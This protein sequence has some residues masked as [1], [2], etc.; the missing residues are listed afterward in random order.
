MWAQPRPALRGQPARHSPSQAGA[1][2]PLLC[3]SSLPAHPRTPGRAPSARCLFCSLRVSVGW[4]VG[5]CCISPADGRQPG[6]SSMAPPQGLWKADTEGQNK[7]LAGEQPRLPVSFIQPKL[8]KIPLQNVFQLPHHLPGTHP[9][10]APCTLHPHKNSRSSDGTR[11]TQC[12][13]AILFFLP[14]IMPPQ[15]SVLTLILT[16]ASGKRG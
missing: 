14:S 13:R 7:S 1:L 10:R 8:Q 16:D 3:L 5:V 12:Q 15:N 4:R 9:A 6:L 2:S 11:D